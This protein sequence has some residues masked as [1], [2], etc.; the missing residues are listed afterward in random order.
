MKCQLMTAS[1]SWPPIVLAP[2]AGVTNYPFRAICRGFGAGV[3][4]SE[5][6]NARGFLEGNA[7]TLL[8]AQCVELFL[9]RVA[10]IRL[11]F[12]EQL[13]HHFAVAAHALHLIKRPLVVREAKPL[14]AVEN[15]LH[16][17]GRRTL[18]IG[19]FDAQNECA[20][21]ASGVYLTW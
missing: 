13:L 1:G 6:I 15:G 8:L 3:Y 18:E 2:M 16:R 9:A 20:L 7:R 21:M 14:H 12:V 4:V 19:V 11:A 5:M 17:F 10:V